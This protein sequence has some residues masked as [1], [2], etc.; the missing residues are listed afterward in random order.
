MSL[1]ASGRCSPSRMG[2]QPELPLRVRRQ[3]DVPA[4]R[5]AWILDGYIELF[6]Q[7]IDDE[8]ELHADDWDAYWAEMVEL[9]VF[10]PTYRSDQFDQRINNTNRPKRLAS[11]RARRDPLLAAGRG[12]GAPRR[13]PVRAR[14]QGRDHRRLARLAAPLLNR[15]RAE[16]LRSPA[17][18]G[19]ALGRPSG[20]REQFELIQ[21]RLDQ[22]DRYTVLIAG[23]Y[24]RP[25]TASRRTPRPRSRQAPPS[26]RPSRSHQCRIPVQIPTRVMPP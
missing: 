2:C 21:L 22:A 26:R 12:R 10:D 23:G 11:T 6:K 1:T 15:N 18:A 4:V 24:R 16:S 25:R 20:P 17:Q 7:R 9:G 14:G 19:A 13:T 3:G 8:Y 5:A